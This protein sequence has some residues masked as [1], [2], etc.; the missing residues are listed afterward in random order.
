[1]AKKMVCKVLI[2]ENHPSKFTYNVTYELI[3]LTN[4]YSDS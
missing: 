4:L 3:I 2:T 1:M